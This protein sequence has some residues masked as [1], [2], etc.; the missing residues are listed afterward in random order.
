MQDLQELKEHT[1][2]EH[3][4]YPVLTETVHELQQIQKVCITM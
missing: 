1:P 4:D 3:V 2:A